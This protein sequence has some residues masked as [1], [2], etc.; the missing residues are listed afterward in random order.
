MTPGRA[1]RFEL[2]LLINGIN[3]KILF[4]AGQG[5]PFILAADLPATG[6]TAEER[7]IAAIGDKL[8]QVVAHGAGPVFVVTHTQH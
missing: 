6:V 8:L 2:T 1:Q 5:P 4:V 7:H 3:V